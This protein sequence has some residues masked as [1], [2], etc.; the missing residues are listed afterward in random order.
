[1]IFFFIKIMCHGIFLF[2]LVS[3]RDM[4]NIS[5]QAEHFFSKLY[6]RI[7]FL[8]RESCHSRFLIKFLVKIV[9]REAEITYKWFRKY[10]AGRTN[11]H[12]KQKRRCPSLN[13]D[14]WGWDAEQDWRNYLWRLSFDWIRL[15]QYFQKF[16]DL[17]YKNS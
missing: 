12:D 10:K 15:T 2:Y 13:H 9:Y 17:L 4:T 5:L 1:M 8:Q 14:W 3:W 16:P 11:I 6:F 7:V